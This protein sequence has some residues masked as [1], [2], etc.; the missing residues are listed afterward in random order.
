MMN[1]TWGNWRMISCAAGRCLNFVTFS[2]KAEKE[3]YDRLLAPAEW[4]RNN[5]LS[6]WERAIMMIIKENHGKTGWLGRVR[7]CSF[8][9]S[10]VGT[11]RSSN[12]G[13]PFTFLV[14][15]VLSSPLGGGT[16]FSFL[17]HSLRPLLKHHLDWIISLF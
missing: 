9:P 3:L 4:E 16:S 7:E 8:L 15:S 1:I 5:P 11:P 2:L 13:D 10:E 14:P 17:F 6:L 12:N